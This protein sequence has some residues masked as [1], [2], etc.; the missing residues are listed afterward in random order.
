LNRIKSQLRPRAARSGCLE[1]VYDTCWNYALSSLG[2]TNGLQ[3]V[4]VQPALLSLVKQSVTKEADSSA[5]TA[6]KLATT[7]LPQYRVGCGDLFSIVVTALCTH[8]QQPLGS[9]MAPSDVSSDGDLPLQPLE[10][11]I[12]SCI[13]AQELIEVLGPAWDSITANFLDT[14]CLPGDGS[15]PQ[16]VSF[17]LSWRPRPES[18][19]AWTTAGVDSP[20]ARHWEVDATT[21]LQPLFNGNRLLAAQAGLEAIF[22]TEEAQQILAKLRGAVTASPGSS[23]PRL[24]SVFSWNVLCETIASR[25]LLDAAGWHRVKWSNRWPSIE[26]VLTN[27]FSADVAMPVVCLQEVQESNLSALNHRRDVQHFL[28]NQNYTCV[29]GADDREHVEAWRGVLEPLGDLAPL[30]DEDPTGQKAP[31]GDG[32]D[33]VDDNSSGSGDVAD[34][35]DVLLEAVAKP[36]EP[37]AESNNSEDGGAIGDESG[38]LKDSPQPAQVRT[39]IDVTSQDFASAMESVELGRATR[40]CGWRS[41]WHADKEGEAFFAK[42][43]LLAWDRRSWTAANCLDPVVIVRLGGECA[44]LTNAVNARPPRQSAVVA[45]LVHR[46]TRAV[47]IF[48]TLQCGGD[49]GGSAQSVLAAKLVL[50]AVAAL[51]GRVARNHRISLD[52]IAVVVCGDLGSKPGGLLPRYLGCEA[53]D[54]DAVEITQSHGQTLVT[55]LQCAGGSNV[56]KLVGSGAHVPNAVGKLARAER[57]ATPR[58]YPTEM[59]ASGSACTDYIYYK[60]P[61]GCHL[62]A[63]LEPVPDTVECLAFPN[64]HVPSSHAWVGAQ[65]TLRKPASVED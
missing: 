19:V 62:S 24:C 22:A 21:L 55:T 25:E 7:V 29:F 50:D 51:R 39:K 43:V 14:S 16:S 65:F 13:I 47:V 37:P 28:E 26:Q 6:E 10:A 46:D 54:A 34:R 18:E 48:C 36:L 15:T 5:T 63:V 56:A 57:S 17:P 20:V 60:L 41:V 61:T 2:I 38:T 45:A 42:G 32:A 4:R 53:L 3:T 58:L 40:G 23:T 27:H 1:L 64:D 59:R 44:R 9:E 11:S 31:L 30:S 52:D 49:T 35:S 33:D 8:V 12:Q